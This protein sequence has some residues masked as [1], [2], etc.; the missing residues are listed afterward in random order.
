MCADEGIRSARAAR[1]DGED[2][3]HDPLEKRDV[4]VNPD[5]QVE[6]AAGALAE[7]PGNFMRVGERE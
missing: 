5:L 1:F 3:L 4:A 2:L 6:V 7:Q